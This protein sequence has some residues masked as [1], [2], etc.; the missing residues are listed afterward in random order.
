MFSK[1]G[2]RIAIASAS[3]L[4]AVGAVAIPA[5]AQASPV[6]PRQ[7]FY[8]QVF[9]IASSSSMQGVIEVA[10]A[11]PAS[12]GHPVAGQYVDVRQ[13]FP[14]VTTTTGYTGNFG[15]EIDAVLIWSQGTITVA[16]PIAKFLS[17]GVAMEIPTSI[18]VP[19]SGS[20]VMNFSPTPDP[21]N[22]G[23]SSAVDV[24]FESPGV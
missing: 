22:S 11:G 9:G 19:C 5:V 6:G 16:T 1:T 18:T 20:G 21:D 15:A 2:C 23:R 8:G 13:I 17:Y 7:Y 24:T 3:A 12:T 4:V 14:P 10:C